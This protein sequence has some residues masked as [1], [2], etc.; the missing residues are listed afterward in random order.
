MFHIRESFDSFHFFFIIYYAEI[1]H[2]EVRNYF[3]PRIKWSISVINE[4]NN[5]RHIYFSISDT[6]VFLY[7]TFKNYVIIITNH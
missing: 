1:S 5:V 6:N 7:L 3:Y 2:Y 4:R